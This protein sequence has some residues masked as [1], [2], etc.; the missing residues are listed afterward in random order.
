M[1]S[2]RF[3]PARKLLFSL[4]LALGSL[5]AQALA[6]QVVG[7][8]TTVIGQ[9]AVIRADAPEVRGAVTRG[10]RIQVGDRLETAAG[11][12][13]HIRFVD[14]GLVSVRPLSRLHIQN[15]AHANK[16]KGGKNHQGSASASIHFN[17]EQGVMR[18]IT[19]AWGEENR[20]RFRLNTPVV[21]IGIKGTDF[22]VQTEPQKTQAHVVT[23]AIVMTPL[24]DCPAGNCQ[25]DDGVLLSANMGKQ[26]LAFDSSRGATSPQ[27][28]AA[29][30]PAQILGPSTLLA[31]TQIQEATKL[32]PAESQIKE[33]FASHA[34]PLSSI[35]DA[36]LPDTQPSPPVEIAADKPMRWLRNAFGWGIPANSI[37]TAR[38][39]Q[40]EQ[41]AG[42]QAIASNFVTTLYRDGL[43]HP[44]YLGG[45]GQASFAMKEGS[46]AYSRP[47][48]FGQPVAIHNPR[49]DVNFQAGTFATQLDLSGSEV[50]SA[51]FATEGRIGPDGA[52]LPKA[53]AG[54]HLAGSLSHDARQAGYLFEQRAAHGQ[55]SGLTLWGH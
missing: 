8:V 9:A 32:S 11:G 48:L 4:T 33:A 39:Q 50:G 2:S 51:R 46:A 42:M 45:Q 26:T 5:P 30:A 16:G 37:A 27:M 17:L 3:L 44:H 19:G 35:P 52:L 22:V 28:I 55:I 54:Q 40:P 34:A 21:A 53:A 12:H 15:Y 13:V 49:L 20:E 47:G 36:P 18:S 24:N 23:G 43:T 29:A 41:M 25:P 7:E 14:G 10:L 38:P 31:A 6:A 1:P